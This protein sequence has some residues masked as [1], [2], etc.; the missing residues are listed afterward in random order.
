MK[1]PNPAHAGRLGPQPFPR[2]SFTRALKGSLLLR[3]VH[4]MHKYARLL[5]HEASPPC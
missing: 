4:M 3:A 1:V 2:G 5:L